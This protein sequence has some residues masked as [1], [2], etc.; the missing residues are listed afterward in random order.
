[1]A[2]ANVTLNNTFDEWRTAT[3]QLI[4][5]V[6]DVD[7]GN[8]IKLY[9]NTAALTITENVAR[10]GRAYITLNVSSSVLDTST[11]NVATAN[12][13]NVVFAA[14]ANTNA[15]LVLVSNDANVINAVAIAGITHSNNAFNQANTA[16]VHANAAFLAANTGTSAALE[17]ANTARIHA[18]AAFLVAN[19]ARDHANVAFDQANTAR[20]HVN[21]AFDQANTARVH[22]NAAF[23]AANTFASDVGTGANSYAIL[24]GSAG[25]SYTRTVGTVGNNFTSLAFDQANTARVHAN[26]S[27]G[28]ANTARVHANTAFEKANEA[29]TL[30]STVSGNTI[31]IIE[32]NR[33]GFLQANLAYEQANTSRDHANAAF[34]AA[35]T[36]LGLGSAFGQANTARVHANAAFAVA[37]AALSNTSGSS[38]AG[39]LQIPTGNLSIGIG[40]N[41]GIR[42]FVSD[43]AILANVYPQ[44]KSLNG[45]QFIQFN[46]NTNSGGWND[47]MLDR[48]ISI[49]Y[50][51][52]LADDNANL[53]IGPWTDSSFG[54][55]QDGAGRHG[56]NTSN[57]RHVLDANG[58]ANISGS[59]LVGAM[60]VV[61]TITASFTHAN[62]SFTHANAA[63]THANA[64]FTHANAA[65]LAANTGIGAALG[66]ANTARDHANAAFTK[67]N[68]GATII[69]TDAVS[70][71]RYI[72][73]TDKTSGVLANANVATAL[74]YNPSSGAFV[75]T[76]LKS[77]ALYDSNNR[78][79]LIKDSAGSVV[80]GN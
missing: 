53:V 5:F 24:I 39:N 80:W 23:L 14:L 60:N 26:V 40:T 25:N 47:L 43:H 29:F 71:T 6:N 59:L 28:Q 74:S 30:A 11:L 54:Y 52:G 8:L 31:P 69:N 79:L 62:A 51:R 32:A 46:A 10:G 17:Q 34:L 3:N 61:P 66:Q 18:N 77:S 36:G 73:F 70:A 72:V 16:R 38:F 64:S 27:F 33:A 15:Q 67:A 50:S 7:S 78:Q 56:F 76:S 48:D 9:S 57:P 20:V 21:V 49:I 12:A 35:N 68:S 2:I 22:A 42:V 63:F 41:Q 13:V 65:F 45:S 37:N 19:T 1:M 4:T 44:I 75:A 58:T 55:K